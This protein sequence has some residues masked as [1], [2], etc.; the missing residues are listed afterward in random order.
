MIRESGV[1]QVVSGKLH[2]IAQEMKTTE[3]INVS[4]SG[5]VSSS[6]EHSERIE[7]RLDSCEV[8]CV[9]QTSRCSDLFIGEDDALDIAGI[10]RS[11]H[12][13]IYGIRNLTD[14]S[15][16]LAQ[17][18]AV[19]SRKVS[20]TMAALF[21]MVFLVMMVALAI[22]GER[23]PGAYA[24]L[25]MVGAVIVGILYILFSLRR[26]G[27]FGNSRISEHT[28]SGGRHELMQ[29]HGALRITSGERHLITPL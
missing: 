9:I 24:A 11:T 12:I 4:E 16:Y 10:W 17:P 7:I 22:H 28:Q 26:W 8:P 3:H 13:D 15:L 29:A 2:S 20:L 18:D 19:E 27:L 1:M 21:G 25:T 5:S 14:G 23:D 6:D